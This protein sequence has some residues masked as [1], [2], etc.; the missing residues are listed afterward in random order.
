MRKTVFFALILATAMSTGFE[1]N[2]TLAT[3]L[4]ITVRNDLGNIEAGVLVTLYK[5]KEDFQKEEHF[6]LKSHTNEK[7]VATFKGVDAVAY[8]VSAVKGDMDNYGAGVQTNPLDAN[9]VNK[10]TIIIE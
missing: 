2:E 3:S 10:V 7:G 4:K 6:V 8:Y 1:W 9:K 5:N